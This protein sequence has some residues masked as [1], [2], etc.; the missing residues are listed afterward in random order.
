MAF[1]LAGVVRPL[2]RDPVD[3]DREWPSERVVLSINDDIYRGTAGTYWWQIFHADH[4]ELRAAG[5]SVSGRMLVVA[6]SRDITLCTAV[7]QAGCGGGDEG[8]PEL[9]DDEA[10]TNAGYRTQPSPPRR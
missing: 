2:V 1:V 8:M 6:S 10:V 9:T 3:G 5:F 7:D 4:S